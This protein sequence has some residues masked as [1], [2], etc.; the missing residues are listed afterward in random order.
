[1][2]L[3]AALIRLGGAATTA[4]LGAQGVGRGRVRTALAGHAV[5]PLGRGAVAL[6]G[7]DQDLVVAVRTRSW[8]TCTS[9]LT[10]WGVP[11]AVEP[12]VPHLASTRHRDERRISWHRLRQPAPV[13]REPDPRTRSVDPLTALAHTCGCL[14]RRDALVAVDG[15]LRQRLVTRRELAGAVSRHDPRGAG[16]VLQHADDRAESP[17]ESVLRHLLLEAGLTRFELQPHLRGVGRVDLLLEGWLVLEADGRAHHSDRADFVRDRDRLAAAGAQ[18]YVTL[19]FGY[20]DLMFQPDRVLA[21]V[22]GTRRAFG[23]DR[24]RTALPA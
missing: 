8:L 19:R 13:D 7:A 24:F 21:A 9:A 12:V 20:D 2:D 3:V 5:V 10:R 1:M 17:L 11:V 16:W 23:P 6:P 18:G 15:A 22:L 14:S 4:E